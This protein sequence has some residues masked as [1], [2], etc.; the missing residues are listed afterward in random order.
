MRIV[1]RGQRPDADEIDANPRA[2][3]ARLRAGERL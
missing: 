1:V 2:R 3:S